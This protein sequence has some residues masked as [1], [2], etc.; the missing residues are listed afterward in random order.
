MNTSFFAKQLPLAFVAI[1]FLFSSALTSAVA[2]QEG[3]QTATVLVR[4]SKSE[5]QV[6]RDQNLQKLIEEREAKAL[7]QA[8]ALQKE[9]Q[10][11]TGFIIQGTVENGINVEQVV[12]DLGKQITELKQKIAQD[13]RTTQRCKRALEAGQQ[14]CDEMI[15][16]LSQSGEIGGPAAGLVENQTDKAPNRGDQ[17]GNQNDAA[18]AKIAE[19]KARLEHA[20]M[21]KQFG[22]EHPSV[23]ALERKIDQTDKASTPSGQA[24]KANWALT[25]LQ[26]ELE[27]VSKQFGADHPLAK[28]LKSQIEILNESAKNRATGNTDGENQVSSQEQLKRLQAEL[29]TVIE[30]D[31][32]KL[33]ELSER[34]EELRRKILN[35]VEYERRIETLEKEAAQHNEFIRLAKQEL[36][37]LANEEVSQIDL[38]AVATSK[39]FLGKFAK[40][41]ISL[42]DGDDARLVAT[43]LESAMI[44]KRDELGQPNVYQIKLKNESPLLAKGLIKLWVDELKFG[45]KANGAIE[46]TKRSLV[47]LK[48]RQ[49]ETQARI[50]ALQ[51]KKDGTDNSAKVTEL[52][53]EL[54]NLDDRIDRATE[55]VKQLQT[56][57]PKVEFQVLESSWALAADEEQEYQGLQTEFPLLPDLED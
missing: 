30:S 40:K 1:C 32:E 25:A 28:D 52:Q 5:Q 36:T 46:R 17:A 51:G 49:D 35:Q 54:A 31:S 20:E 10:R 42:F 11:D 14:A 38:A 18:T 50:S 22:P 23:K 26:S 4:V 53:S 34:F 2:A 44:V 55:F 24:D 47:K 33:A 27:L 21:L 19:T 6:Q 56:Q 12:Q 7:D 45:I 3:W 43:Q 57:L 8:A 41:Y 16:T 29:Q 48:K 39:Q 37:R 9:M 13:R 15:W